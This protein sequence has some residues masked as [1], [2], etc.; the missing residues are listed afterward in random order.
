MLSELPK[1]I[2]HVILH[3]RKI[4]DFN[5]G[6]CSCAYSDS[7]GKASKLLSFPSTQEETTEV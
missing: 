7:F 2:F 5:Q 3:Y 1:D 4:W 6:Q